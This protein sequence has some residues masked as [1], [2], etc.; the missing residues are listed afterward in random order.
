MEIP[1]WHFAVPSIAGRI[2]IP[3][4]SAGD[5]VFDTLDGGFFGY[6]GVDWLLLTNSNMNAPA[7]KFSTS[8]GQSIP[9][10]NTWTTISFSTSDQV[11]SNT[12]SSI[13]NGSYQIMQ[14]GIYSVSAAARLST[15]TAALG[16]AIFVNQEAEPR[17]S[18]ISIPSGANADVATV[19]DI[20]QV[21]AGDQVRIAVS[22]G[23]GANWSL[24]PDKK[25]NRFS[26]H[27]VS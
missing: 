23:A 3:N 5:V 26:I 20:V 15:N 17:S 11:F 13:V 24:T 2:N 10:T 14:A 18:A 7:A 6:N 4:P 9:G 1:M 12:T 8:S 25:V 19:T 27:R 16:I 22:Q 21:S